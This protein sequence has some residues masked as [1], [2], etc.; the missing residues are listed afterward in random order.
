MGSFQ[1]RRHKDSAAGGAVVVV[2][3]PAGFEVRY[4]D[5]AQLHSCEHSAKKDALKESLPSAAKMELMLAC[6]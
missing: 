5:V 2:G 1:R 6:C 4:L 3:K